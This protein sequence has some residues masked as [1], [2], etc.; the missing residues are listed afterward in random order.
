[1]ARRYN[2][3]DLQGN[4]VNTR[5]LAVLAVVAGALAIPAA[6]QAAAPT[7][8]TGPAKNVT[9]SGA[10]LTGAINPNGSE[11]N[12]Y[13]EY[14]PTTAYGTKTVLTPLG[15]GTHTL[16]VSAAVS[17]LQAATKYHF[18]LVALGG[19][20][21]HGADRSFTTPRVPLSI[22]LTTSPNP[23]TFGNAFFVE[24]TLSGTGNAGHP[25]TL[26]ARPFPYTAPFFNVGDTHIT[27]ADGSFAFTFL[28]LLQNAQL[29]VVSPGSPPSTIVTE[30]VAVNVTLHV[31]RAHRRGF[32]RLFGR[33]T[34]PEAGAQIAFER[35]K[36][37][38]GYVTV[39]GATVRSGPAGSS[40]FSKVIRARPG[41]YRVLVLINDAQHVFSRSPS[42]VIR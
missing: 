26:Q 38:T 23:V 14:G 22:S 1:M 10:T 7:V 28:G 11:T 12:Y 2:A 36:P 41:V 34:P 30:G 15:N 16:S 39:N 17:G 40:H 25:V 31:A 32:A 5:L 19:A 35:L 9:F 3:H 18:R 20:T 4:L 37:R 6:A 21:G 29:R 8:T 13:F 24:G 27:N 33:V 42:V